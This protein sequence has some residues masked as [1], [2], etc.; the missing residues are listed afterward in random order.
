MKIENGIMK[1][2]EGRL[3][4]N[5]Y[6]KDNM[7]NILATKNIRNTIE[8]VQKISSQDNVEHQK[9]TTSDAIKQVLS[10]D[11]SKVLDDEIYGNNVMSFID[12]MQSMYVSFE[13]IIR[14]RYDKEELSDEAIQNSFSTCVLGAYKSISEKAM[15]ESEK[16][17]N[18]MK[19]A[20]IPISDLTEK[21]EGR[22]EKDDRDSK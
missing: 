11:T 7:R 5:V 21:L 19:E 8:Y 15:G 12:D 10:L 13:K 18:M 1:I 9:I 16:L 22:D 17:L 3:Q 14:E 20:G 4:S 6:R 2:I